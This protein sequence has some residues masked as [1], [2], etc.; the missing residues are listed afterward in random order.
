MK[1]TDITNEAMV[2]PKRG[3]NYY[4]LTKDV[5]VRYVAYQTNPTG[6]TG[7]M[8]HNTPGYLKGK[9]GA[10]IIDYYG[11]HYYVDMKAKFATSIYDLDDQPWKRKPVYKEVDLAPDFASW[12]KYKEEISF[13]RE[14]VD[15]VD[16]HSKNSP[17]HKPDWS[18]LH[19]E[20]LNE[21]DVVA[22]WPVI[23]SILPYALQLFG[24][25]V[26]RLGAA[27]NKAG[28]IVKQYLKD[29]EN[30]GRYMVQLW[31]KAVANP[32]LRQA[33]RDWETIVE[34]RVR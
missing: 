10:Y 26:N 22:W 30:K 19:G 25:G 12:K 14:S 32:A 7:V 11:G 29:S 27:V 20:S 3:H 13:K 23:W 17:S 34:H 18:K 1:L 4:Q 9:K 31:K 24:Y 28:S 21:V 33:D 16:Y 6:A 15:E 5:P 2:Q 8:L